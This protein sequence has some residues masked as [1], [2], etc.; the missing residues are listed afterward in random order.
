M[1]AEG[2]GAYDAILLDVDNGPE[3]LV[4]QTNDRL[5]DVWGLRRARWSLRPGGVLGIWSRRVRQVVPVCPGR[6]C[7]VSGTWFCYV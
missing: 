2:P 6:G 1:I 7:S 5:Y 4:Q 3:G